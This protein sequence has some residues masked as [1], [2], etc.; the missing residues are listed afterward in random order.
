MTSVLVYA[1][2]LIVAALYV[3]ALIDCFRT[4]TANIRLLPKAGWLIIMVLFPILGAITWRNLG[5][6]S[7][8]VRN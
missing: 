2:Y 6:R 8:S 1:I 7:V 3:Y 4:P 5:T